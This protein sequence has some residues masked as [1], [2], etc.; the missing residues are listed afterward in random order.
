[1]TAGSTTGRPVTRSL[2][3]MGKS[4]RNAVTPDDICERYGA[5]T[6]RLYEMSMGPLEVSRPWETRAILGSHRFL[7]RLWRNVVDEET[8]E[9]VVDDEPAP[10]DLLRLL[11]RT[12]AEVGEDLAGFRLST[13]LARLTTL[14]NAL[15]RLGRSPRSVVEPLVL[16]LAPLAPHVAEELWSRLGHPGSLVRTPFPV[17]DPALLEEET[18]T[19][20]V[21][22]DGKV[23]ARLQVDAGIAEEELVAL[24]HDA[25]RALVGD[26]PARTVVRRPALVSF[27]VG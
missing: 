4:L 27:V 1:M 11:H 15:G 18:V 3:K 13:V 6:L 21:Q 7:Q 17:A 26:R 25:V 12:V 8:G 16:M 10:D 23:R 9:P 19:C 2:G 5:D 22:V 14:N 20:V 24:A